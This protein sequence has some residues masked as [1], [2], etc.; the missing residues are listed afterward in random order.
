MKKLQYTILVAVF[1]VL[2]LP[3]SA[4][5]KPTIVVGDGIEAIGHYMSNSNGAN[6]LQGLIN[7]AKASIE[8]CNEAEFNSAMRQI[9]DMKQ[10]LEGLS[11]A[12]PDAASSGFLM[13]PDDAKLDAGAAAWAERGLN[14]MWAKAQPCDTPKEEEPK[15]ALR[16]D[17]AVDGTQAKPESPLRV[18]A[19]G[20]HG[21]M[22]P[23]RTSYLGTRNGGGD[24]LDFV[25]AGG[26]IVKTAYA[27]SFGYRLLGFN[28]YNTPNV[29]NARQIFNFLYFPFTGIRLVGGVEGGTADEHENFDTLDP[30]GATLLI[31]GTGVGANG[32]GFSLVGPNNQIT[33]AMYES[34]HKYHNIRIGLEGDVQTSD[35][36]LRVT[37]S[38]GFEYGRSTTNTM[39]MGTVPVFARTFAYDTKTEVTT[40]SP[41]LGLEIGYRTSPLVEIFGG[42]NYAYN[43]NSGDG[44]D[45]LAFTGFADQTAETGSDTNTHSY[46]AKAGITINPDGPASITFQG[47]YDK[48]G[49]YPV[50]KP[51]NGQGLSDFSYED[52]DVFSAT[53]RATFKF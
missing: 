5:A 49:N 50:L 38:I 47:N 52:A 25:Q 21:T 13:N 3:T 43:I 11:R 27:L 20:S 24:I 16:N 28:L 26:S 29:Y 37:P 41:T 7:R 46:G 1:A 39:F 32:A 14:D 2:I 6:N 9:G 15:T 45:S 34:K 10:Q 23:K 8:A 51:R 40:Y 31:P 12:R 4:Q 22:K 17:S 19:E 30:M 35:P 36:A 18:S 53:L 42:A 48:V 44:T 33:G